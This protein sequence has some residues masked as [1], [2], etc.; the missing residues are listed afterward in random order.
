MVQ[1]A[2][3]R[4]LWADEAVLALNIIDRSFL[5]LLQ[6]LDY[7]Q[8]A[9]VGFLMIEKLAVQALGNHEYALRL[10]P[11][12]TGIAALFLLY[13]LA[14]R[15]LPWQAIP[16]ALLL[17][18]SSKHVIY[19]A[20]EV[21]QYSSDIAIA[22]LS[23][24]LATN[25]LAQKLRTRQLLLISVV[26]GISIWFSHPAIFVLAG[27]GTLVLLLK[28]VEGERENALKISMVQGTWLLSFLVCYLI[29]LRDLSSNQDLLTSWG[30]AFPAS[31]F[32]LLWFLDALGK[33]F[34]QPLGF[35][36]PFDVLAILVF[37][38]G[39]ASYGKKNL[40][41]LLVLLSPI[42]VTLLAAC[43]QKYPFQARLVLF[44]IPFFIL[45]M[46]EGLT[47]LRTRRSMWLSGV[48]TVLLVC[49]LAPP[50]LDASQLLVKP[51]LREEIKPV[52]AY[53]R[54]HQQPE[55]VLYI[56]QRGEYQFKYY[57]ERYGYQKGDYIIG[58]DDLD[59]YDQ[60]KEVSAAEW[61][62][63]QADLDQLRGNPR[64]WLLFSHSLLKQENEMIQTYLNQIG[65]RIDSFERPGAFV[66]LYNLQK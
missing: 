66:Y 33:F 64:V 56:F 5:E 44:L 40:K 13:E 28:L 11:L 22:L 18:A 14:K 38:A 21:K 62:R 4:S 2:S 54:E 37:L 39:C 43:L 46:A 65:Q 8:G 60:Q 32:D 19:Y 12:L 49:L 52:I 20:S 41:T 45:L 7:D 23:S 16:I 58:V 55:D 61:K 51:K 63:Y 29:S 30:D 15:C 1:Y 47:Y 6:P 10:F 48:G 24:L 9:P 36:G 42:L 27:V 26:G 50:L 3:N 17:F 25:L 59:Q 53:V 31:P 34:Y 35:A 57:A